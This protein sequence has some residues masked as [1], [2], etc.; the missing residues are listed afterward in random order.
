MA[1]TDDDETEA[2][3]AE[4]TRLRQKV[5]RH[6]KLLD[7]AG[8]TIVRDS[9]QLVRVLSELERSETTTKAQLQQ[10]LRFQRALQSNQLAD[11]RISVQTIYLPAE[12]IS[13]DVYDL[14][15]VEE[16]LVRVFVAD[17]TGHG[18]AAG[19][20]TMFIKSEYE[21]Q[22]R[23]QGGP[24][25]VLRAMNELLTSRYANL[26][27]RFTALCLD[28]HLDER[29]IVYAAGAHP[30]PLVVRSSGVQ[31]LPT[32]GTYLGLVREGSFPENSVEF[33]RGDALVA[34]TD[35]LPDA[36][37]VDGAL[38]GSERVKTVVAEAHASGKV[39]SAL[40]VERLS[41]FVGE[42]RRLPDDVTIVALGF[43]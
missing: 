4:V 17:A 27:L 32:G 28:V 31:E 43:N 37:T 11:P 30:G 2:L 1:R 25:E 19:L 34:F 26:E 10:A 33:T 6:Q 12:I 3:R 39:P 41:A 9:A 13:G 42:G 14:A 7:E 16:S 22:K 5:A 20:A 29:R 23:V 8:Q 35:G 40:L 21:A 38:F 15:V 36:D 18:V 24:A